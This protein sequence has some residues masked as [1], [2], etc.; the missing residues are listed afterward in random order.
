MKITT[1]NSKV[2]K[3]WSKL[4]SLI[5]V[6][7]CTKIADLFTNSFRAVFIFL[8]THAEISAFSRSIQIYIYI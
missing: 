8:L 4:C 3:N 1:C 2:L 6:F 7:A 5:N